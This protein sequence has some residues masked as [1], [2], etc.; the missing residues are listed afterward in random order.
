MIISVKEGD[1]ISKNKKVIVGILAFAMI[2]YVSMPKSAALEKPETLLSLLKTN[3][4][5]STSHAGDF[6][7]FILA[8]QEKEEAEKKAKAKAEKKKAEENKKQQKLEQT[9]NNSQSMNLGNF[10][11]T[12]YC[13]CGICNPG[14]T[15]RTAT[16]TTITPGRTVAVDKSIIPL[17]SKLSINGQIY[18]AEDT[19][20]FGRKIDIAVNSHAKAYQKGVY[21][22][23]VILLK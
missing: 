20:V 12:H 16:G 11:I 15:G 14:N 1:C 4:E 18:I 7:K 19:G 5:F 10:K 22:A 3:V 9:E 13:S 23:N 21:N 8:K 17:G 6:A 2:M